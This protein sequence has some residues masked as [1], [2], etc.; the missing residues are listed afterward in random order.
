MIKTELAEPG[1]IIFTREVWEHERANASSNI[2]VQL[3][4]ISAY[5]QK[6]NPRPE[7]N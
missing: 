3:L 7:E 5:A 6:L 1:P 2:Y 4:V